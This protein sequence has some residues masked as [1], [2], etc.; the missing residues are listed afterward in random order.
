MITLP[1]EMRTPIE[2]HLSARPHD[3]AEKIQR[4]SFSTMQLAKV[5]FRGM[6]CCFQRRA[7][8]PHRHQLSPSALMIYASDAVFSFL[9]AGDNQN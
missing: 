7:K 9:F 8:I 6:K 1:I 5:N 2:R 4:S 3:N